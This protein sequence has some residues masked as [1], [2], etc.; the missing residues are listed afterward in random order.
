V[1]VAGGGGGAGGPSSDFCS[2]PGICQ[3]SVGGGDGGAGGALAA[4]RGADGVNY[5]VLNPPPGQLPGGG[6]GGGG[7]TNSAGGSSAGDGN[8]TCHG[9]TGNTSGGL[10]GLGGHGGD[11]AGGAGSGGGGGGGYFG[12]GGGSGG[13]S[14]SSGLP[15]GGNNGGG[16]GGGGGGSSFAAPAATGV[17][18]TVGGNLGD[19]SA[20]VT[21]GEH[22]LTISK[23]GPGGVTS[24]PAGIDC[25][26]TCTHAFD[27]G[28]SVKLTAKPAAGATFVGWFGGG[29]SGTGTCT[30]TMS[31][32]RTV[33]ATFNA[34][35]VGPGGAGTTG[36][37]GSGGGGS[38]SLPAVQLVGSPTPSAIGVVLKLRCS[39]AAGQSCRTTERLTSTETI[40]RGHPIAVTNQKRK[41]RVVVV[42]S[43]SATTSAGN[44]QTITI[45]LNGLGHSLLTRF[46]KLPVT[47]TIRVSTHGRTTN[48]ATRQLTIKQKKKRPG[49]V[50]RN[51]SD[52]PRGAL[53]EQELAAMPKPLWPPQA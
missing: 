45:T 15:S 26:A 24:D 47:L 51:R 30:V 1:L 17:T 4:E 41:Q 2:A 42:G 46:H 44:T 22:A 36:G 12:G 48:V 20:T 14:T 16:G 39:A 23:S 6:C 18:M 37:G 3:T 33:T 49:S 27:Q 50:R 8:T 29:C 13:G 5:V 28:T 7:G 40:N 31:S 38:G 53:D 21:Y 43:A 11:T 10:Q 19:G 52:G 32:D 35:A 34:A 9:P 25:G